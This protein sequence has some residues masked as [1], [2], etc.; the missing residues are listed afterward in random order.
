M[1]GFIHFC[2]DVGRKATPCPLWACIYTS[3]KCVTHRKVVTVQQNCV[4]VCIISDIKSYYS[5]NQLNADDAST[6]PTAR[7]LFFSVQVVNCIS[8]SFHLS[9]GREIG[10][11]NMDGNDAHHFLTWPTKIIY[12]QSPTLSP[13]RGS[14]SP[15]VEWRCS[16][17]RRK[18]PGSLTVER[19][20]SPP[21]SPF[22]T[23]CLS[24]SL[25]HTGL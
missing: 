10:Q 14:W 18:T 22:Y 24:L 3:S 25:T 7:F 8:Q 4:C 21:T 16:I 19:S 11:Q 2:A 15:L 17:T 9:W 1:S 20:L 6:L 5:S 23:R 12:A 13:P